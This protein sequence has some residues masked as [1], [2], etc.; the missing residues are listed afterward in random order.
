[1]AGREILSETH[2]QQTPPDAETV[3][4]WLEIHVP[5]LPGESWSEFIARRRAAAAAYRTRNPDV[6]LRP[7][8]TPHVP[9]TT[10][11]ATHRGRRFSRP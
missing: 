7:P 11:K 4:E 6:P 1:M 10:D 2:K 5:Q 9:A 3:V 8:E